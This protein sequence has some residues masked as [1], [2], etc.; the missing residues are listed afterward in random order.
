MAKGS[1]HKFLE[2]K[3]EGLG[4]YSD[5]CLPQSILY[6]AV[7]QTVDEGLSIG[8]TTMKNPD[9]IWFCSVDEFEWGIT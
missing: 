9:S 1:L 3:E 7:P 2:L 6:M 8:I 5:T 4:I